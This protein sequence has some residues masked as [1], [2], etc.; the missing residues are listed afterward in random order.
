MYKKSLPYSL[1][2]S[3]YVILLFFPIFSSQKINTGLI[4]THKNTP[5][6]IS[7]ILLHSSDFS[8][9]FCLESFLQLCDSIK[10]LQDKM[11]TIVILTGDFKESQDINT[12]QILKKQLKGFVKANHI[13]FP[14]L[15]DQSSILNNFSNGR[16]AL[17]FVDTRYRLIKKWFL[18]IQHDEMEELFLI[19]NDPH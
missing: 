8:C 9:Q 4:P 2:T 17:I 16:S 5:K 3:I 14:V 7:L 6:A 13:P 1:F 10:R 12:I 19:L 15:L 18:P 11:I